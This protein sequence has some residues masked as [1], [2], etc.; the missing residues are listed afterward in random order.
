MPKVRCP[1]CDGN[2]V[3]GENDETCPECRGKGY[4]YKPQWEVDKE[5]N[6]SRES[7][8]MPRGGREK[9]E[10][11]LLLRERKPKLKYEVPDPRCALIG[12]LVVVGCVAWVF[13]LAGVTWE[14][15]PPLK[16]LCIVPTIIGAIIASAAFLPRLIRRIRK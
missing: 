13:R 7:N 15:W 10:G 2:G 4:T 11:Y 14:Q 12:M 5:K 9:Y 16:W 1:L 6:R 8:T 3:V